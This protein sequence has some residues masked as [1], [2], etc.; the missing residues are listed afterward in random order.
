M[1]EKFDLLKASNEIK[2]R[3]ACR[4]LY[5]LTIANRD[6]LPNVSEIQQHERLAAYSEL[7][8][9]VLPSIES[10]LTW[11][12]NAG[13]NTQMLL[14]FCERWQCSHLVTKVISEITNE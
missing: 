14:T 13:D 9:R 8:H 6:S 5:Y 4:L 11:N 10:L 3:F 2:S 1:D 7:C 12:K